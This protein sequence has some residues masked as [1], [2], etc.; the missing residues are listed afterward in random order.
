MQTPL[1]TAGLPSAPVQSSPLQ[2]PPPPPPPPQILNVPT[3]TPPTVPVIPIVPTA[4]M[5]PKL[6]LLDTATVA[7]A[8]QVVSQPALIGRGTTVVVSVTVV[9]S[10]GTVGLSIVLQGANRDDNWTSI[11]NFVATNLGVTTSNPLDAVAF[12]RIRAIVGDIANATQIVCDVEAVVSK[13][14]SGAIAGG[15]RRRQMGEP[16]EVSPAPAMPGDG[17]V[18]TKLE[19]ER[20]RALRLLEQMSR[21]TTGVLMQDVGPG[22]QPPVAP[23]PGVR[24]FDDSF[25]MSRKEYERTLQVPPPVAGRIPGATEGCHAVTI[26]FDPGIHFHTAWGVPFSPELPAPRANANTELGPLAIPYEPDEMGANM[27]WP[28]HVTWH[29]QVIAVCRGNY[30][31]CTL[32][33]YITRDESRYRK[34]GDSVDTPTFGAK[35]PVPREDTLAGPMARFVLPGGI[36][37][38]DWPG[39]AFADS[40]LYFV[41]DVTFMAV[42]TGTDG[43][44]A[45]LE[46]RLTAKWSHEAKS[47][48][49]P[50]LDF[51]RATVLHRK[52]D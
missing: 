21:G 41:L 50:T 19:A 5:P 31:L 33:R 26:W 27:G 3:P 2:S 20:R 36:S 48:K 28:A 6:K 8:G 24:R 11:G 34:V 16:L 52:D 45:E 13:D 4:G 37:D 14:K 44:T 7:V 51:A 18:V 30:P 43:S 9:N 32:K 29:Y 40:W 10:S 47:G 35:K 49:K 25:G 39:L 22:Q 23:P 38:T 17:D 15:G 46:Y 12:E 1:P 42:L